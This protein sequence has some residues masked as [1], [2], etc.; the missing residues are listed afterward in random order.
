MNSRKPK[1]CA[2]FIH[3]LVIGM[4]AGSLGCPVA[5]QASGPGGPSSDGLQADGAP[6]DA[7][8]SAPPLSV[9]GGLPVASFTANPNPAACNQPVMFDAS[10][11]YHQDPARTIVLYEWDLDN[12]EVFDD[13]D[14]D[15]V[16]DALDNCPTV[17][18]PDQADAD[19]DGVG[20]ACEGLIPAGTDCW[21]TQCGQTHAS[22][23]NFPIPADFFGPGSDPFTEGVYLR[24]EGGGQ[25]DTR[26]AR[27]QDVVLPALGS[28]APIEIELVELNLV[29]CAPILVHVQGQPP[30]EW[31]VQVTLSPT[32]APL[33]QMVVTKTHENGGTFVSEFS[34][35]PVF[36]FTRVDDPS[37]V[38][39]LDTGAEGMP[40]DNLLILGPAP[41]VHSANGSLGPIPDP[42]GIN[43]VPGVEEDRATQEQCCVPVCHNG[44]M[45]SHCVSVGEGC[46]PGCTP[47]PS[48]VPDSTCTDGWDNDCDGL[49]DCADPDCQPDPGCTP[50]TIRSW[51]SVGTH[52][53]NVGELPI[54]LTP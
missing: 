36:T 47:P 12:D 29:S 26:V 10:A 54:E 5:P 15:G 25:P 40:P 11:S 41:W 19:G 43:F 45:T 24:G 49:T 2:A 20:D 35:Q 32:A 53:N 7:V 34:V 17:P 4:M 1:H 27:L 3:L 23:G 48:E 52:G 30:I 28:A 31:D 13:G 38:R 14:D 22:F 9:T 42:C 21:V 8:P 50:P 16:H 46:T 18:N 51:K 44:A 39:V 6:K 33:G 37:Q